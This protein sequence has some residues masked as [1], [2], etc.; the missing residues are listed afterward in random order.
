MGY[1]NLIYQYKMDCLV[2]A[3]K[4]NKDYYRDGAL[5]PEESISFSVTIMPFDNSI[6]LPKID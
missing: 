5:E 4:Y 2:A 1:Y 6:N 3:L